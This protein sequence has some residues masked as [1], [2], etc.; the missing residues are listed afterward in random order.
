MSDYGALLERHKPLLRYDKQEAYYADSAAEW[1]DAP[2]QVLQRKDGTPIAV[3]PPTGPLALGFLAPGHY[4]N[5]ERATAEDCISRPTR[6]YVAAARQLHAQSRYGNRVYGRWA[7]GSDGR[8][9]LQ[10]WFFYFYNNFNLVGKLLPAGLHEGDW[11]MVQLRLDDAEEAPDLAVYAQHKHA[12]AKDWTAI[13]RD[14]ERP[15]VYPARGSH[16]S[17]FTRGTHWTGVWFDHAD[18][19][20]ASPP[21]TL[22]IVEDGS[23]A[24]AWMRWPGF[25]GDTKPS[26]DP[27]DAFSPR[28]PGHHAQWRDPYALLQTA[29]DF[30][31]YVLPVRGPAPTPPPA[32][33]IVLTRAGTTLRVAYDCPD[34]P[35]GTRPAQL[36]LTLNSPQEPLPPT[37][38]RAPIS[39]PSGTVDFADA[40]RDDWSYDVVASVVDSAQVASASTAASLPAAV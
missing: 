8:T 26:G 16:A 19:H 24:H 33:Q 30:E 22:E 10:Y 36:V 32:P 15:V 2:G 18:G 7:S 25:W 28:G 23:A 27:V 14:G 4:G 5:G 21:L 37:I 13:E 20:G 6:D 29:E 35:A 40:L 9:W 38:L 39:A 34:W 3:A 1:T 12:A 11:E 31:R 17:Y